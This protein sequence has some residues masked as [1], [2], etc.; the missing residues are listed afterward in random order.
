MSLVNTNAGILLV[1]NF[2]RD[3]THK[4]HEQRTNPRAE[5]SGVHREGLK[6]EH[7]K[8]VQ[9]TMHLSA[10]TQFEHKQSNFKC[11]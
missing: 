8:S 7:R 9:A 3:V 4:V 1:R 10:S 11:K 6:P 5:V 2:D